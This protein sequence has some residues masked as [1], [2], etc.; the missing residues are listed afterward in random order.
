MQASYGNAQDNNEYQGPGLGRTLLPIAAWAGLGMTDNWLKKDKFLQENRG[1]YRQVKPLSGTARDA[2]FD[3][4]Y[5]K[6]FHGVLNKTPEAQMAWKAEAKTAM[7]KKSAST[8]TSRALGVANFLFL[9][10]MLYG[11]TYHGFK[12]LQRLGYELERPE[13]GGGHL[14]L[15]AMAATDRQRA[16]QAMHDSEFNGRSALGQ[17][18]FLYHR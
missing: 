16:M 5:N 12:G 3:K 9:A 2:A 10:P 15:T 18:A 11:A 1:L 17:E 7:W 4:Y 8:V 14:S 6:K 13:V